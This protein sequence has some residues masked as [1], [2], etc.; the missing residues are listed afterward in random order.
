[1][2]LERYAWNVNGMRVV[3]HLDDSDAFTGVMTYCRGSDVHELRDAAEQMA[4]ALT[5][6]ATQVAGCRKVTVEGDK[7]RHAL[8]AD[9]GRR[10]VAALAAAGF[11]QEDNHDNEAG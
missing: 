9:G 1:M 7:A 8:D 10:A 5:W 4:A 2:N 6:Y 3:G 11:K